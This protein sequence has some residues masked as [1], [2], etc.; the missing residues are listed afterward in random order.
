MSAKCLL[1][2]FVPVWQLDLVRPILEA[3]GDPVHLSRKV[4]CDRYT[5]RGV[6]GKL[7][8]ICISRTVQTPG[9][10][11]CLELMEKSG[12]Y[13]G[14]TRVSINFR[15]WNPRS[16]IYMDSLNQPREIT[17]G[18]V[19]AFPETRGAFSGIVV[20]IESGTLAWSRWFPTLKSDLE[21]YD[22]KA[23]IL[24]HWSKYY[25]FL[26]PDDARSLAAEFEIVCPRNLTLAEANRLASRMLYRLA[27]DQGWRKLTLREKKR[28]GLEDI[29]QWIRADII[30]SI[31]VKMGLSSRPS[32]VG[33]YT[34][35]A[36]SGKRCGISD[37]DGFIRDSYGSV[38]ETT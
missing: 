24:W 18:S 31:R 20:S 36:A 5:L 25:N 13:D 32:G 14:A 7:I 10:L 15:E 33:D 38:Y 2:V 6:P 28:Y 12:R 26:Q 17:P 34:D 27:R 29:G 9:R 8:D 11:I 35:S 3:T 37:E 30:E 21:G 22:L 23:I 1:R 4:V 16:K 19:R